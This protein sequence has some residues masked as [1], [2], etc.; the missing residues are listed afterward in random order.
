MD[1]SENTEQQTNQTIEVSYVRTLWIEYKVN[2]SFSYVP[3]CN[4]DYK[5]AHSSGM[6]NA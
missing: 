3:T 1:I 6:T 4:E 5:F 2:L